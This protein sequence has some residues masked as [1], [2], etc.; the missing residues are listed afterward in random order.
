MSKDVRIVNNI[1]QL[2]GSFFSSIRVTLLVWFCLL[3]I[4]VA[5]WAE[6]PFPEY[7][8][9]APNIVF[10]EKVYSA[11]PST[12]GLIH[13]NLNLSIIYEVIDL[14]PQDQYGARKINRK[15]VKSAKKKYQEILKR[16]GQGDQPDNPEE[17]RVKMLWGRNSSP[18]VFQKAAESI[19]FQLCQRDRFIPGVIRSGA[20]LEE[21]KEIFDSY[22]AELLNK[23][24]SLLYFLYGCWLQG[25]QGR[26]MAINHFMRLL[27]VAYPRSWT[28]A[29]H[30]LSGDLSYYGSW[31][32]KAFLWEKR[33]FLQKS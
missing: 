23:G 10:W 33:L 18:D 2:S 13:D 8:V 6:D 22:P 3:S 4:P 15:R 1:F 7:D 5:A 19:R 20:F 30:E 29:S 27:H 32:E 12:K 25:T 11:Y 26:E 24:S 17:T 31:E 21:I 28:L 14:L 16:L 9:I